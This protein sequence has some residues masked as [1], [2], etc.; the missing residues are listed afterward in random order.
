MTIQLQIDDLI[1]AMTSLAALIIA[2]IALIYTVK[3]YLLKSGTQIRGTYS[4]CS[5]RTSYEPYINTVT[6]ENMKDKPVVVLGIYLKLGFNH[7]LLLEDFSKVPL[8][9]NPFEAIKREYDALAFYQ[10]GISNQFIMKMTF[11]NHDHK[12]RLVL[13]T[14]RGKFVVRDNIDY[15]SPQMDVSKNHYTKVIQPA[16]FKYKNKSYGMKI[17]YLVDVNFENNKNIVYPLLRPGIQNL[18]TSALRYLNIPQESLTSKDSLETTLKNKIAS[19][20]FICKSFKVIDY[21]EYCKA[22]LL[23]GWPQGQIHANFIG[24]FQYFVVGR[25]ISL[26]RNIK[27]KR[28]LKKILPKKFNNTS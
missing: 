14:T 16:R 3:T 1:T 26:V 2:I 22:R 7:Y 6:I 24:R 21:H 12:N 28:W 11:F 20:E 25:L 13:R 18:E 8:I 9:L 17:G 10:I 27:Q 15:W 19:G 5:D 23:L 4:Y